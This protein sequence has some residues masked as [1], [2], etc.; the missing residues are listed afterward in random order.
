MSKPHYTDPAFIKLVI[1]P[2]A[3]Q[4]ADAHRKAFTGYNVHDVLVVRTQEPGVTQVKAF[5]LD[6]FLQ[7][8]GIKNYEPQKPTEKSGQETS[9]A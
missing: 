5:S 4:K 2:D 8:L 9:E 3:Q 6:E 7:V 1:T